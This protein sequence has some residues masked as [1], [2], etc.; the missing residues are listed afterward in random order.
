MLN[1]TITVASFIL[2]AW[3]SNES[4]TI[5]SAN[6][7]QHIQLTKIQQQLLELKK[8]N[9]K[10]HDLLKVTQQQTKT[11]LKVKEKKKEKS[12]AQSK[13]KLKKTT[14]AK[15]QKKKITPK[16][17]EILKKYLASIETHIKNKQL[18]DASKKLSEFKT[19][20]WK[21]RNRKDINKQQLI[22]ILSSIDILQKKLKSNDSKGDYSTKK[23]KQKISDLT[24]NKRANNEK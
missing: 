15:N 16:E 12:H 2:I 3:L 1:K 21:T 20:V 10:T 5:K 24:K 4:L 23:L 9:Q 19:M 6:S 22:P 7:L 18:N 13:P 14:D 11:P 8:D 17:F